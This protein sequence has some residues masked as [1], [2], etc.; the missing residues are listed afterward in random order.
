MGLILI[1]WSS[2]GIWWLGFEGGAL[3]EDWGMEVEDDIFWLV[4]GSM[5][6]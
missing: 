3:K 1:R 6:I 2:R 5:A 4:M